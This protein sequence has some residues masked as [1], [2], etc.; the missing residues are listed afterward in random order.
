MA[1]SPPST[2]TDPAEIARFEALAGQW[3]DADGPHGVLHRLNPTRLAYVRD[4]LGPLAARAIKARP[5]KARAIKARP[6]K[7]PSTEVPPTKAP[8]LAGLAVLD[9]GCGGGLA[10]EPLAR[11]GARV[12]GIDA[13]ERA[14]AV[15]VEHARDAGL[16]IAYRQAT[17]EA[18]AEDGA[19]FDALVAL[20]IV[21]HV[22]DIAAFLGACV[23]VVRPG[24]RIVLSTLNRTLR[25]YALA[26]VG[27]ERMLRWLPPGT[28]DWS[29]FPK[30]SE[31]ARA[32]RGHGARVIDVTGLVYDPP[33]AAW[34][35][36]RDTGVNYMATA[37]VED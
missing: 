23:A 6:T 37:V 34:R 19:R 21:E 1:V 25:S 22:P 32:L 8:P 3:W 18:L 2:R 33:R 28:H 7:V 31:L 26:I 24:G 14:I 5:T 20:E 29:K 11:L 13:G 9:V 17:V 16:A 36:G 35:L 30:P 15:A 4:Q 12:T 10:C 27:A